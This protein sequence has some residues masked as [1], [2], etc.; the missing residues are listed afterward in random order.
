MTPI[1]WKREIVEPADIIDGIKSIEGKTV[2]THPLTPE[3]WLPAETLYE[4][5]AAGMALR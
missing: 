3:G 2:W 4:W 5:A 1:S